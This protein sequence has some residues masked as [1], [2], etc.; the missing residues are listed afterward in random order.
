MIQRVQSIWLFIASALSFLTLKLSFYSGTFLPDNQYHQ[1]NGTDNILLMIVTIALGVV[2]L[3]NIFLYKT[4]VIQLRLCIIG[5]L[6][7]L[8]LLY[9]YFRAIPN[10]SQ[11][12]YSITAASHLVILIALIFS[13]R[14]INKDEK[15]VKDSDRL[16]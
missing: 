11:G 4:R 10:Y 15:I 7:D 8:L 13:A 12:T 3:L 14:G 16:R 9:L 5:I 2:S 1:L 6:L